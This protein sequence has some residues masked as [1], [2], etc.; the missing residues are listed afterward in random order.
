M[1]DL[2]IFDLYDIMTLVSILFYC[3]FIGYLTDD[4]DYIWVDISPN[5]EVD[6]PEKKYDFDYF[7]EQAEL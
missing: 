4:S 2:S 5:L 1:I 6:L 7:Q 3:Y